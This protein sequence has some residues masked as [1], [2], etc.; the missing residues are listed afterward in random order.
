MKLL[1]GVKHL[2][3][4]VYAGLNLTVDLNVIKRKFYVSGNYCILGNTHTMDDLIKL[5]LMETY[6]L[7]VLTYATAVMPLTK[8]QVNELNICWNSVY[9]RIFGFNRWESVLVFIKG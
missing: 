5:K 8:S 9:R 2:N 3:I 7:P 4:L 1:N 6:C